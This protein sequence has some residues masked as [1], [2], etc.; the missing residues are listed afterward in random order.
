MSEV[1]LGQL[2]ADPAAGRDAVHV[3]II[4]MRAVRRMMPGERLANGIVDPFLTAPVEPGERFYLCLYPGTV[5]GM[6]HHWTAPAFP[7]EPQPAPN[8]RSEADV[9]ADEG[10]RE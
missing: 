10:D 5:T 3:A 2:V 8:R 7:D 4:P 6:R 9:W 1:K